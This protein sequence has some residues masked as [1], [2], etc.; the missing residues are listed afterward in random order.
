MI[1]DRSQNGSALLELS[2]V[3]LVLMLLFLGVFEATRAFQAHLA[4]NTIS[5]H[6]GVTVYQDC[7]NQM[8][9][10]ALRL[11]TQ[12]SCYQSRSAA[13]LAMERNSNVLKEANSRLGLHTS[14]WEWDATGGACVEVFPPVQNNATHVVA[15]SRINTADVSFARLCQQL[16]QLTVAEA[17]YRYRPGIPAIS[18]MFGFR[19]R[20]LYAVGIL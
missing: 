9:R 8:T 3:T 11:G 4:V 13:V 10:Q 20:T 12:A 18:G 6:A 17:F 14:Y 7:N 19:E 16:Q 15:T 2:V 1:D 5:R